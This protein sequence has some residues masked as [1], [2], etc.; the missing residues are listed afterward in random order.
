MENILYRSR[1]VRSPSDPGTEIV[2]EEIFENSG[3]SEKKR[4]LWTTTLLV[5]C[6]YAAGCFSQ[7]HATG[8]HQVISLDSGHLEIHGLAFITPTTVTGQEEEMQAVAFTFAEVLK[9]ERPRIKV[10]T[11][12]E[13]LSAVNRAAL[14][15]DYKRMYEDYRNTGIFERDTLREVGEVTGTTYLAQLKLSGFGQDSDGRFS[16]FGLRLIRTKSARIRLFF[17][18]WDAADGAIV[19]EGVEE[20]NYAT[21]QFSEDP[22]T[23]REVLEEAAEELVSRLPSKLP[24]SD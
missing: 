17:Q 8:K 16:L 9:R 13:T 24:A 2:P 3:M 20:V 19:W 7:K 6:L 11:L 5:I 1:A 22:V 21:D 23:L 15:E 12:P 18:I 4:L 14:V 10:V